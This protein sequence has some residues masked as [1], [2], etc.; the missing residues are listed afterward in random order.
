MADALSPAVPGEA[1]GVADDERL[2]V[3]PAM[4]VEALDARFATIYL[5]LD[6]TRI[7]IPI[8]L[9]RLLLEFETPRSVSV[10]LGDGRYGAKAGAALESLRA[11]GF[12]V[13]E[14]A[15]A[16]AT[17]RRLLT[18]APVRI[19]DAPAQKL[20]PS[21]SDFVVLGVAYDLSDR[22]AA[23]AR[24]APAALRESSLQI[25][26]GVDRHDGKPLG[27]YDSD[28]RRPILRGATISDCGDVFVARGEEQAALFARVEEVLGKVT[29]AGSLPVLLGGDASITYPAIRCL[30]GRQSIAVIRIA[31]DARSRGAVH[32]S[33]VS[34]VTLPAHALSLPGVTRYVHLGALGSADP[35]VAGLA[36]LSA[37]ELREAGGE[38]AL[39]RCLADCPRVYVSMDIRALAPPGGRDDGVAPSAHFEYTELH[40]LLCQIGAQCQ[41]VGMD[42][43]GCTPMARCWGV[44]SMTALHV[45]LTAMS[46]AKDR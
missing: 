20:E 8:A 27:W 7:R 16:T 32:P 19:F 36:V 44:T 13:R 33:F 39:A 9:H 18:D 38:E 28:R 2:V 1:A 22:S 3:S 45:L 12:L 26:Y 21:R 4:Q 35:N 30:Q 24:E 25:L 37:P 14:D 5:Q 31:A 10:V 41:I 23:G 46:A 43:V 29:G 17:H 42:L 15:T 6:G 11:K 34:P 40:R